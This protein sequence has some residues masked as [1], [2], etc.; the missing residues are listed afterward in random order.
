MEEI[1]CHQLNDIES[2]I[3]YEEKN[4]YYINNLNSDSN[5]FLYEKI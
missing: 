3:D 1:R 5:Y 2:I 4:G